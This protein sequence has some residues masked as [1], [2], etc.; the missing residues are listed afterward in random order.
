MCH[1][2]S[3]ISSRSSL[4][5]TLNTKSTTQLNPSNCARRIYLV[6]SSGHGLWGSGT[7]GGALA[8][9]VALAAAV[10][11]RG[12]LCLA[13]GGEQVGSAQLDVVVEVQPELFRGAG[14]QVLLEQVDLGTSQRLG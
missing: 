5:T 14:V 13:R 11:A 7:T 2:Y 8:G 9:V 10:V 12:S 6:C 4:T 3:N 1:K